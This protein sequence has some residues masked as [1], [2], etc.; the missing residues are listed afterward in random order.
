MITGRLPS[1]Q[2]SKKI[3][4]LA[5]GGFAREVAWLISDINRVWTISRNLIGFWEQGTERIMQP[6]YGVRVLSS[7]DV[8]DCLPGFF[9]VVA[10]GDP[11]VRQGAAEQARPFGFSFAALSH[12]SVQYGQSTI[13]IGHGATVWAGSILTVNI[14]IGNHVIVNLDCTIG[15]DSVLEDYVT[16]S[17]GFV[18][19]DDTQ[20]FAKV[21]PLEL[22]Q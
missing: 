13:D 8:E 5:R 17:P 16:L 9:A 12:P 21:L 18:H 11:D 20:P 14:C 15:H 19:Q 2:T 3:G 7:E 6:I 4:S 22:E 10:S 1:S